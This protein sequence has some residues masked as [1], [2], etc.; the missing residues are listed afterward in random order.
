MS[1]S[2]TLL[3]DNWLNLA[4]LYEQLAS[5]QQKIFAALAPLKGELT[6][7]LGA[8][9]STDFAAAESAL[10]QAIAGAGAELATKTEAERAA[11]EGKLEHTLA[12][13]RETVKSF[14]A[15]TLAAVEAKQRDLDVIRAKNMGE[16]NDKLTELSQQHTK[17]QLEL[18]R[19]AAEAARLTTRFKGNYS[20]TTV[21]N[22][23]DWFTSRGSSY[24]VLKDGVV[25]QLP[26]AQSQ[27]GPDATYAVL[28]ASGAPGNQGVKG[29]D[30]VAGGLA[31]LTDAATTAWDLTNPVAKWTLGGNRTLTVS[32]QTAGATYILHVIQSTG[33]N[34]VTW[35]ASVKWPGNV[36]PTLTVTAAYRDIFSFVS[37]GTYLFAAYVQ[38]YNV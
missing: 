9:F 10:K 24:L 12:V 18:V 2:T 6:E 17:K 33:S 38:N 21:Y 31:T 34:T 23:D 26:T 11:L 14:S 22:R 32:N 19:G 5:E 30:L 7:Q 25:N 16:V 37:D 15:E 28:A 8:K 3:D 13:M 1:T 27:R 36:A 35:P 20:S 4:E 29:Q